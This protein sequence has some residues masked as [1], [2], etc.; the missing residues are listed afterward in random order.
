MVIRN[1]KCFDG[2]SEIK[3]YIRHFLIENEKSGNQSEISECIYTSGLMGRFLHLKIH[4]IGGERHKYL[5]IQ[6][7]KIL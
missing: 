7:W 1:Q 4:L 6:S 5:R 3:K 2:H